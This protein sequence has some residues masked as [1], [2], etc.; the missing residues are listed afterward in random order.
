M[1]TV[2]VQFAILRGYVNIIVE[3]LLNRFVSICQRVIDELDAD[4]IASRFLPRHERQPFIQG[5]G[6][7]PATMEQCDGA[8]TV[9]ATF[10]FG[11][12]NNSHRRSRQLDHA[13]RHVVSNV[14]AVFA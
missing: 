3:N 11:T 5:C 13:N 9:P 8:N 1:G 4:M 2:R 7:G 12:G 6:V 14:C 10:P